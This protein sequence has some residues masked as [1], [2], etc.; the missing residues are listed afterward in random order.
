VVCAAG[1]DRRLPRDDL[2][3]F[4]NQLTVVFE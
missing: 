1:V 2:V 4:L 3:I